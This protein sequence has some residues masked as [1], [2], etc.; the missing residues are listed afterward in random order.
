[1]SEIKIA[2]WGAIIF[3]VFV[4]IW[5]PILFPPIKDPIDL[6]WRWWNIEKQINSNAKIYKK[7]DAENWYINKLYIK[8]EKI[9][10]KIERLEIET[11]IDFEKEAFNNNKIE[12]YKL[13]IKNIKIDIENKYDNIDGFNRETKWLY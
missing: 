6:D 3:F 9:E 2:I 12:D 8:I 11:S 13:D 1:M 4:K 5:L 7:I 10:N